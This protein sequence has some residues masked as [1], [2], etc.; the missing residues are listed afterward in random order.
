MLYYSTIN[1]DLHQLLSELMKSEIFQPFRLVGGTALSLQI[2]HRISVDIDLF[3][4]LEYG[5]IDFEAIEE[6]LKSKFSYFDSTGVRI[7]GMG[8]TYFVGP[9]V[10]KAVKLDIYYTDLF[11][12]DYI[13]MYG[14]RMASISEIIAM[15]LDV[16]QR[17]GRKKDF[18]DLHELIAK[19]SIQQML[20]LHQKRYAFS[21]D[22]DLILKNFTE[23]K[24]AD[25]DFDPVCLRGKYWQ[26]VKEDIELAIQ[27]F[28]EKN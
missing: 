10:Q 24:E 25:D 21:H 28:M 7:A 26:F 13:N 12:E 22:R 9:S 6:Y 8:K 19:Y 2:G 23:F 4:D 1:P 27:H 18:W 3:T 16:I 17:G 14:V 5:R 20:D 15:K 11:I